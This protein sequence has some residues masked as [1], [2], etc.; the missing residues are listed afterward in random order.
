MSRRAKVWAVKARA[1]L[2][3][4]LGR[5]CVWCGVTENLTFD[6]KIPQG[7]EHHRMSTDQRMT[8]YRRQHQQRNLQVLCDKCNSQK[9]NEL[10]VQIHYQF[11]LPDPG[12]IPF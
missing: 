12:N 1:E 5:R 7:D 11:P 4:V 6:C 9:G 10:D 8:F 2:M 3:D